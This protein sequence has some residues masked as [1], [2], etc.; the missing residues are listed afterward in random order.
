MKSYRPEELFDDDGGLRPELA[1]LAPQGERRMG[2]NPHANGGLLLRDLKLPDYADYALAV[3]QPGAV[4]GEATR[5][6]GDFLRDVMQ[7]NLPRRNFRVMGPDETVSKSLF[8]HHV[9]DLHVVEEAI[10]IVYLL[11]FMARLFISTRRLRDIFNPVGLA[12]L[13]VTASL[14]TPSLAENFVFLR[15]I[16]AL[17]LLRSYHMINNLRRQSKFVRIHEDVIFS[18][19][20][21]WSSF[22]L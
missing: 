12:D 1:A 4:L 20:S 15:V 16:R 18:I 10:G 13:I 6:L 11:E 5:R 17:R 8:F 9:D 19:S 7:R 14:L 22:S 21:C 2:A 3:P